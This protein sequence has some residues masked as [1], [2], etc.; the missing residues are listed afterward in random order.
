MFTNNSQLY[1]KKFSFATG[2]IVRN[3]SSGR[4]AGLFLFPW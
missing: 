3:Y 2:L 4:E 1:N